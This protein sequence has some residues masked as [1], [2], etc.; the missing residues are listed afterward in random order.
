MINTAKPHIPRLALVGGGP[1]AA[2]ALRQF[3]EMQDAGRGII[4]GYY[5]TN[6]LEGKAGPTRTVAMESGV[7]VDDDPDGMMGLKG[8]DLVFSI[9]NPK[10]FS[11][12]EIAKPRAGII[13]FHAAPLPDYRGSAVPA[14]AIINGETEFGVTFH[15][16][17]PA[18]DT[19]P[20]IHLERFPITEEMTAKEVDQNCIEV[21]I[22]CLEDRIEDFVAGRYQEIEQR[23]GPPPY[24]RADME[25][26]RKTVRR[27]VLL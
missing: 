4:L 16:V 15:K 10:I 19:G 14:F 3:V 26:R 13:N 11:A 17:V 18:I 9:G 8:L 22:K 5:P 27:L 23:E 12:V 20:I 25:S 1:V 24:H 2:F 6:A 7:P 21:G